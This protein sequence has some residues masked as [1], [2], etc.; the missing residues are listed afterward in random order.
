ML[1]EEDD[2][3]EDS[4]EGESFA[5]SD[6]ESSAA[7]SVGENEQSYSGSIVKESVRIPSP[8]KVACEKTAEDF[9]D[10]NDK[11]NDM[12]G[13]PIIKINSSDQ[14]ENNPKVDPTQN[15]NNRSPNN[16]WNINNTLYKEPSPTLEAQSENFMEE[17]PRLISGVSEKLKNLLSRQTP[18]KEKLKE[19]NTED[20]FY[21]AIGKST[22]VM[23]ETESKPVIVEQRIT[24]SQ[25]RKQFLNPIMSD[26]ECYTSNESEM[27]INVAQRLEEVGGK[28]GLR[29]EKSKGKDG[30]KKGQRGD[31]KGKK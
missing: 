3:E 31:A 23:S 18:I 2:D 21:H 22:P 6:D 26:S 28:C 12:V 5:T 24:R 25:S 20:H 1:E 11:G 16:E 4:E 8:Q 13:S 30:R 10:L 27:S 15:E 14:M 7:G 9:G 29:K 19:V 17:S